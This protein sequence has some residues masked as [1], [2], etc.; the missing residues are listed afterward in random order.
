[1]GLS[2]KHFIKIAEILNHQLSF[3]PT[4]GKIRAYQIC[5]FDDLF[6][7]LTASLS[8]YFQTENARFD[9]QRFKEAV[10]KGAE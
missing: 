2:K 3:K 10:F 5:L 8:D 6:D 1:M 4:D 9:R 7:D